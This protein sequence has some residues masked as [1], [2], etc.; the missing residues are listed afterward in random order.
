MSPAFELTNRDGKPIGDLR[1]WK[2]LASPGE[3]RW[4]KGRSAQ[5]LARSWLSEHGPEALGNLLNHRPELASFAIRSGVA[6]ARTT[7]DDFGGPRNHDLLLSGEAEGGQTVVAVEGKVD[8]TFGPTLAG[9]RDE[10]RRRIARKENTNL[11]ERLRGLTMSIAGWEAGAAASRLELRYQL[12][13]AVAGTLAAAVD[14]QAEQAVFCIHELITDGIDEKNRKRN[15][16]DMKRFLDVVFGA[17]VKGDDDPSWIV[18]PFRAHGGSERVPSGI[19]FY[20]AKLSTPAAS[21]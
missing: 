4:K 9:R 18:G 7:F 17:Y 10:A 15:E 5:E 21:G 13:T 3:R 8:E 2:R 12:F 1:A 11:P 20:I 14:A 19:P 6:E 16:D